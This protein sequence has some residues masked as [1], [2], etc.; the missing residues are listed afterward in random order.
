[1]EFIE[2][3]SDSALAELK[4]ANAELVTM[5]ANVDNVGKKMKNISSPSGSDGAIKSLTEQYK[6]QE[7]V[8]VKLQ[9]QIQKL[10]EKKNV[11]NNA[12]AKT[13]RALENETK[14]RQAL[15]AQRQR[16]LTA[17]DKEVAKLKASENV[18]NKIQ[19]KMN[20]LSAEYK[21]LATRRELGI[22]LTD[23][24]AK[25]YDFL[26]GKIQ[27]YDKTLKAVDATMG[28]YQRNVGNYASG[29]NPLSNSINQLTREMPAFTNSVQTGFMA[30]SNNIPIFTDAISNA[31]AQ[32]KALQSE[33]KPTTSVLKQL[34]GAF[35]SWQTLLGVGITLLTVYGKE[36]GEFISKSFGASK[37]VDALKEAQKQLNDASQEGAKNAVEE[38][39]KLKSLLAIAKDTTLTY[40]QRMIAVKELQSTYPAYF[41]NL[42]TEK[43]LTGQTAQAERELTEAILSRAK[44]NAAVSKIT[45]N[46]AKIIDN[47]LLK[48]EKIILLKNEEERLARLNNENTKKSTDNLRTK[49]AGSK[50]LIKQTTEEISK[51]KEEIKVYEVINKTLTSFALEKQKEAILLDYKEE[52]A[53]RDLTKAKRDLTKA[54]REDIE[55]VTLQTETQEG[56]LKKLKDQQGA[57][58]NLQQQVSDT[59][60]EYEDF[61]TIIEGLQQAIDLIEDP[62]KVIKSDGINEFMN[63][64]SNRV[65]TGL[66]ETKGF[67][68]EYGQEVTDLSQ[69]LIN[70]LAEISNARFENQLINL[71]KERDVAILF[72]GESVSAREEVERQYEARR[73]EIQRKQA[74]A[75]KKMAM[76]NIVTDTAQAVIASFIRD[77]TG[78]LAILIGAIGAAQLALVASQP[79][80]QFWQGTDNAP[81]G[82]AW[83]QEKGREIITD[84]SGKIK[85]LGSDKGAQLTMLD[86]GDKVFTAEKSALMFDN[87][88]NSILANNG[89]SMPKIEVNFETEKITNEIKSLSNAILKKE[90]LTII[91]NAKG[92]KVYLR[93]QGETKELL[94]SV[95]NYKT[96][97]V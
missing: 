68:E 80:P 40:Q 72:A 5:V 71:Q 18:Y 32:N 16:A 17:L 11:E 86:K 61:K 19:A 90:G 25:R 12:I 45:E 73:A 74:E 63:I 20:L 42:S 24:E 57:F 56:F 26:Q 77:P 35:F 84:K 38:N 50:G 65:K 94:N 54:K 97:N 29:F 47:E 60:K 82:L 27:T 69:E 79:I 23:K 9:T 67:W 95:I 87:G 78:V 46:Q 33:G 75:Q 85:S 52:K 48:Q 41:D 62:S 13:M 58:K 36:I 89:I 4:K 53:K 66:E 88:L 96:I 22:T 76:F 81:E 6:Q 2:F 28:K 30:L 59:S 31:I 10:I 55:T 37:S 34:A 92:E 7:A 44:A 14:S 1:M 21:N 51:L 83:T 49:I 39:L 91:K 93:K 15:D 3:L 8:I 64:Y 43:I 70:T